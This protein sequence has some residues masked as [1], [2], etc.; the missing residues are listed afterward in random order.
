MIEKNIFQ[1]WFTTD[2]H[3]EIREVINKIQR[4]IPE[5]NYHL[6]LDQDMDKFVNE[7]FPR[8]IADCYNRLNI[9]VAKVDFWRYLILYK[10]GG[11]YLDMDSTI[12]VPLNDL[13]Q[14]EDCAIIT[15]E[16]NPNMFVQWALIFSKGHPIL[17]KTIELICQNIK[18]NRY[19]ND[20]HKM[21]GPTVYSEAIN[22]IH[23]QLFNGSE[24]NHC[25]INGNTN[26][27]YNSN[28]ISYRVYGIDFNGGLTFKH[29]KSHLLY[30][31]KKHWREEIKTRQLLAIQ[32][33]EV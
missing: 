23:K 4:L 19:P 15:A 9:I 1:S 33:L 21:T 27:T 25:Q 18:S 20:I 13:I 17:K 29:D 28:N 26:I 5:Y 14:N 10:Y 22:T 8:E 16:N 7:H 31:N 11:V 12:E 32:T 3:P 2:L 6:Y 30:V 24:I